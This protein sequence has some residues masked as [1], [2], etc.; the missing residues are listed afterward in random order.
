M[1]ELEA[2]RCALAGDEPN[3]A[4]SGPAD[5]DACRRDAH[6]GASSHGSSSSSRVTLTLHERDARDRTKAAPPPTGRDPAH[7]QFTD[8]CFT[9]EYPTRLRDREGPPQQKQLSFLAE[10]G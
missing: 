8:H 3:R 7:P 4:V 1:G 6:T 10:V 2:R 9:G 5:P